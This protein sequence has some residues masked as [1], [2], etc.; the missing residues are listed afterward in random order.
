LAGPRGRIEWRA[1]VAQRIECRPPEPKAQVRV[2]SG[3]P[4]TASALAHSNAAAFGRDPAGIAAIC[5]MPLPQRAPGSGAARPARR[6]R[7]AGRRALRVAGQVERR[8][9]P[10]YDRL[11]S[12]KPWGVTMTNDLLREV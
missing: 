8:R 11:P 5:P 12:G 2:L 1:P 9:S 7:P 3:V 6:T 4:V 10:V